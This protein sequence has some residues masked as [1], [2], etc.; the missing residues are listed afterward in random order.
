MM[1]MMIIKFLSTVAM[2]FSDR[3]R[4]LLVSAWQMSPTT[5]QKTKAV[6]H[7]AGTSTCCPLEQWFLC[8]LSSTRTRTHRQFILPPRRL[9]IKAWAAKTSPFSLFPLYLPFRQVTS[10]QLL[11]RRGAHADTLTALL[12]M[13]DS[14][15]LWHSLPTE[16]QQH[17]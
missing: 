12:S 1:P 11:C 13:N 3:T 2:G 15:L 17:Q 9:N 8:V 7:I 6:V 16:L 10:L 5:N 4:R 14:I